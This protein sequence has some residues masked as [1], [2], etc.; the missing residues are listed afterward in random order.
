MGRGNVDKLT[1]DAGEIVDRLLHGGATVCGICREY[2]VA[3]A[4]LMRPYRSRTTA[5]QRDR[6]R[7]RNLLRGNKAHRFRAGHTPW[8]KG[9][10]HC[11]AGSRATQFKPGH[12]RGAAAR[13]W[14]PVGSITIHYDKPPKHLRGRKRKAGMPPWRG[15]ARRWIKVRDDGPPG[16]RWVPYA[17]HVWTRAHGP[18]GRGLFVVHVDGDILN[19]RLANLRLVDNRGHLALQIARN[20][21]MMK[22]CRSR[23][24]EA[25]RLRHRTNRERRKLDGPMVTQWE[26]R[27]CGFSHEDRSAP[28][29]CP[30]CG[31]HTFE[32]IRR[33]KTA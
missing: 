11:P 26:C 25:A 9:K 31:G 22:L 7:R 5:A 8:N 19:D 23:A 13:K 33:R 16:R 15:K 21:V 17:R 29:R 1:A 2:R 24:G 30:K 4:T 6:V 14:R 10:R 18:I 12:M 20:P 3:Y 32:K 27:A 28:P